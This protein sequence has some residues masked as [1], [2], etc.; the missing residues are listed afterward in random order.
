MNKR[1][2]I[3]QAARYTLIA[4]AAIEAGSATTAWAANTNA[5]AQLGK[6]TVTGTRK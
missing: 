3:N 5:P 4:A 6:I 1:H 2:R